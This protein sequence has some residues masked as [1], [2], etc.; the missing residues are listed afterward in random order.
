MHR[1][2]QDI[3]ARMRT[4]YIHEHQARYRTAIGDVQQRINCVSMA[5]RVKMNKRLIK[6]REQAEEL[7]SYEEKI[8]HLADQFCRID[9]DDGVKHNYGI[10][11]E[12]LAKIR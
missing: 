10:F 4:D 7:R 12:V 1:Y 2:Q 11:R 6:L 8:H 3:L 5:E 9:L